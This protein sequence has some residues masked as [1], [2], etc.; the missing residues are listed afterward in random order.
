ML[1]GA[2]AGGSSAGQSV[3]GWRFEASRVG[4]PDDVVT[5][6]EPELRPAAVAAAVQ[7]P[8]QIFDELAD[9]LERAASAL[10][11]DLEA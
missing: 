9:R 1:P 4:R 7:D 3:A 8:E 11:V 10:G 5:S 6:S 2:V